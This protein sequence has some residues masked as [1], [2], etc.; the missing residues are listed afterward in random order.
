[1]EVKLQVGKESAEV[2][3]AIAE[4]IKDI[5]AKKGIQ[6]LASENLGNL[7]AAVDGVDLIDDEMK[8]E[9]R[10]ATIAYAGYMVADAIV[11]Y[12]APVVDPAPVV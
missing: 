12:V 4:L 7:I 2:V 3:N 5:K 6:E 11:P 8:G 9:Y 10:N 1:M